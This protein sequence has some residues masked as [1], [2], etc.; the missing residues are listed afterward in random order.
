[1][2]EESRD[3]EIS[4]VV[5]GRDFERALRFFKKRTSDI[6]RE[7][8]KRRRFQPTLTRHAR[9]LRGKKTEQRK[10][11]QAQSEA[12]KMGWRREE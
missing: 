3:H 1:M 12:E 6:A 8:K 11:L 9:H 4:V 10:R 5:V 7:A 2:K